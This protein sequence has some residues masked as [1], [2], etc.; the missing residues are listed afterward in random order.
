MQTHGVDEPGKSATPFF[1]ATAAAATD[2]EAA[3]YFTMN[4]AT[5]LKKGVA[6]ELMIKRAEGQTLKECRYCRER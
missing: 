4:G 1:L 3:I 5:L 6:Q 2:I